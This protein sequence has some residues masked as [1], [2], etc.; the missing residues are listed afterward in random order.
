VGTEQDGGKKDT[1]GA[2]RP[3]RDPNQPTP[4]PAKRR[5]GAFAVKL[6]V[7][8]LVSVVLIWAGMYS[9]E[10]GRGPWAWSAEDRAGFLTFSRAQVDQA[11]AQVEAVDWDAVKTKITAKTKQLWDQ[12]PGLEDRLE[13][14]LAE[15]RGQRQ[16]AP[17]TT[18]TTT[19]APGQAPAPTTEAAAV[20]PAKPSAL[21]VGCEAMR[22]GIQHYRR[23]PNSQAELRL[24]KADFERAQTSLEAAHGEAEA[25]GD[26]ASVQEIEGY[27]EQCNMYLE[28]CS[29]RAI[30]H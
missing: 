9:V 14:R 1:G 2:K 29:K 21:E 30:V 23:S 3:K 27:L 18:S 15:L 10:I 26:Q 20:P 8:G 7:G 4:K 5:P 13:K 22:T 11:R 19:S 25:K 6:L 28:D 16:G 24:A 17:T 12:V